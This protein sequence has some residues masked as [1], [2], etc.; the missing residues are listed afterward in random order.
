MSNYLRVKQLSMES[1][2]R[3][4]MILYANMFVYNFALLVRERKLYLLK[5]MLMLNVTYFAF[6]KY[7][8]YEFIFCL[9]FNYMFYVYC[10]MH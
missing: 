9:C 8:L 3:K 1:C 2:S 10:Y 4:F 5:Y 7:R 6:L